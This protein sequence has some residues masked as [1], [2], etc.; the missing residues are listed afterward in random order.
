MFS[1]QNYVEKSS[2]TPGF[3]YNFSP[4]TAYTFG[5]SKSSP[6]EHSV[7]VNSSPGAVYIGNSSPDNPA[8]KGRTCPVIGSNNGSPQ[9]SDNGSV[10][11]SYKFEDFQDAS[12]LQTYVDNFGA[13]EGFH[14]TMKEYCSRSDK[15]SS[16]DCKL[17]SSQYQDNTGY[18]SNSSSNS[19]PSV[20][21]KKN[22]P[23]YHTDDS[24][25]YEHHSN[26]H[27]SGHKRAG[28]PDNEGNGFWIMLVIIILIVLIIW[29]VYDYRRRHQGGHHLGGMGMGGMGVKM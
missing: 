1:P 16:E 10:N 28:D 12:D 8:H 4:G 29:I 20:N 23:M 26:K 6:D 5:S 14:E 17:W 15:E 7:S 24:R 21:S 27:E 11:C 3:H 18:H 19:S 9:V 13:D 22:Y 2:A 25:D